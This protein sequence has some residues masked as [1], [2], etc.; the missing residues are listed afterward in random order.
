SF[1][2]NPTI[3]ELT[4]Q[5]LDQP[6]RATPS[7]FASLDH[8]GERPLSHGQQSLWAIQHVSTESTAYNVAFAA[9]IS[10]ELNLNALRD[11]CGRLVQRHPMLRASF[12]SQHGK[13]VCI[14]QEHAESLLR[15]ED[16]TCFTEDELFNHLNEDAWTSFDL[17]SGP[18][19]RASLLK[20][21]AHEHV[22]LLSAHHIIVDFWSLEVLLR[23][24]AQLYEDR[25][26]ILDTPTPYS[27]YVRRQTDL[28]AAFEGE[29]LRNYWLQQL[30]GELP[31]L[32]LPTDRA[33]PPM[34][35]HRGASV[36]AGFDPR[37]TNA[38]K[39][40][41][42]SHEATLFM[43]LLSA[44]QVL[45]SRYTSQEEFLV[46]SPSSGRV[47]A[48]FA[49]TIG[50][51]IN[52]L[53]LRAKISGDRSFSEFLAETRL[54]TLA[55]FEHQEYPFDLLVKQLQPARDPA[56]SPLFQ[57]MFAFQKGDVALKLGGL[58]VESLALDQ[59]AAQFDLSLTVTEVDSKLDASFEYNTDLFDRSTIESLSESFR[60]LLDSIVTDPCV[61]LSELSLLSNEMRR[62]VLYDWNDTRVNYAPVVC[63]HE[64]FAQRAA[65]APAQIAITSGAETLSYGELNKRANRLANYLRARGVGPEVRVG[66][67]VPRSA[68][69][70]TCVL[71]VLKAGGAYVPLDP[72]YPEERLAFMIE[73]S[74]ASLVL[75]E[76]LLDADGPAIDAESD[77]DP[78]P[79]ATFDNLAYVIYTSGST[80]TPKGV[81]VQHGSLAN[82]VN[83]A[84]DVY[85]VVPEDR[86]LQFFSFSFDGHA[87]EIYLSLT[88]GATLVLR[89][90]GVAK[91]PSAFLDECRGKKLTVITLPTAYWHELVSHLN[92]ADWTA[93][94]QLQLVIIGGEKVLAER[95]ERW[96][97]DVGPRVR[98]VNTYGPTEATVIA[99]ICELT[100]FSVVTIGRPIANTQAYVLDHQ[101]Q[102]L[103][104]GARGELY[105]G[106]ANISRGYLGNAPLTAEKFI[107]DPFGAPG[108][109]LYRTGDLARFRHDGQ[110]E[111]HGRVDQQ[112]KIRGHRIEPAEIE[113]T[114]LR[115]EAVRDVAVVAGGEADSERRLLAY[116]VTASERAVTAAELRNFLTG[117]LPKHMLPASFTVVAALP[118][119]PSGK[120]DRRALPPPAMDLVR[121]DRAY[122]APRTAVERVLCDL[123]GEVLKLERVGI[124]DN[125]FEL[126]GDSILS[127]Q[128]AARARLSGLQLSPT[129]IFQHPTP[130]TLAAVTSIARAHYPADEKITGDVPLT[131]IQRWFFEQQFSF[132]DHWNMA[133]MLETRERLDSGLL[134][135]AF[136]H[137][138]EHHDALHLRFVKA[139]EGW[140]QFIADVNGKT[141]CIVDLSDEAVEIDQRVRTITDETQAQLDLATGT[142]LRAVLLECGEGRP[143]RLFI[144][145]HHLVVDGVSWR[146]LLEDLGRVYR[147]LQH[148]E[149]VSFPPKTTSFARWA[150]LLAEYARSEQA[151]S[152]LVYWTELSAKQIEP[153][154]V[155]FNDGNN[156]EGDTHT[157]TIAL[158]S[159]ETQALLR[160]VAHAYTTQ[161][162]DVL[163]TALLDAIAHWTGEQAILIELEGHGREDLFDD[164]D[165]SRTVGWFTS[166]FPILLQAKAG[167]SP[168]ETLQSVKQQLRRIPR[169]GVGY[170]L[171]RYL[172]DDDDVAQE[173]RRSPAPEISFNYLGQWDQMLDDSALF[174]LVRESCGQTRHPST[175]R[176][177]LLEINAYVS[178]KRLQVDWIYGT[179]I[180]KHQTIEKLA[181][182]FVKTLRAIINQSEPDDVEDLYPLSP[183]Q[184]GMLFH[185]VYTP[186]STIYTGQLSFTLEGKL[187]VEAFTVAWRRGVARH[188]ILRSSFIWENLEE[189]LQ[190]V[191]RNVEAPLRQY[192]WRELPKLEQESRLNDLLEEERRRGFDLAVAPLMRLKLVQL[193]D[194]SYRFIWTHHHLLLDGWSIALLLEEIFDD[195]DALR[196][197]TDRAPQPTRP[198]RDYITWLGQQDG[199]RAKAFWRSYLDGFLA[200]TPLAVDHAAADPAREADTRRLRVRLS[201]AESDRLRAFARQHQLTLSTLFQGAWARLL[202]CYSR[203]SDVVYGA[204]VAGRP[205]GF[206]GVE[207]MVGLF[208]NTLPVRVRLQAETAVVA[209]LKQIQAEQVLAREYEHSP[210]V[211]LQ[212]LSAVPRGVPLFESLLVFEN[213]PLDVRA[214]GSD[215]GISASDVWWF[216]QTNYPL[217]VVVTP[218]SE[219]SLEIFYDAHRFA[220]DAIQRMLGHVQTILDGFTAGPAR[221]LAHIPLVTARERSVLLSQW[222]DTRNESSL[223]GRSVHYL[224]EEQAQK[225]PDRVALVSG[226]EQLT[227]AELNA[228]ANR[229]ARFL[230]RNGVET[231]SRVCICLEPGI[232]MIVAVLAV[233]KAGA[234]YVPLDPA[235]PD[236][237]LAFMLVDSGARVL[238]TESRL[239]EDRLTPGAVRA[240][241]LDR[242]RDEILRESPD[243]RSVNVSDDNLIYVIYTSGSTGRPKGAAVTHGGFINLVN[244]FVSEFALTERERVLIIASFSFDLTQKDIFSPLIVGGQL[245]FRAAS[246]YDPAEILATISDKEI[247]FVNCTPSAFYPLVEADGSRFQKLS[248]LKHVFLGGEPI[249]VSRLREWA[250]RADAEIVNTY[251]PTEATD[252][253]SAFRLSDFERRTSAPPIG[254]PGDNAELLILDEH[255]NLLP[256]SVAGELFIGGAGV[257]RGYVNDPSTTAERFIPHPYSSAP[258][259]RLY[260][261]GDLVRHLSDGN[262]EFLGRLDHQVKVA[263]YRIELGEIEATMVQLQA[264]RECVVVVRSD[265]HDNA[266]L[267]AYV[268]P[269]QDVQLPDVPALR[270]Y[271]G[272]SLPSHMIPGVFVSLEKLP[273]T[274]GGKVDRRALPAPGMTSNGAAPQYVAPRT[275]VEQGLAEIWREVLGVERVGI[276]DNF[277]DLGGHS[278]LA[279]R[280]VSGIRQLFRIELPLRVLFESANLEELA[281]AVKA[282]PQITR[283]LKNDLRNPRREERDD[284][285]LSFA[286]ERLWFLDQLEPGGAAYNMPGAVWLEG[287]LDVVALERSLNEIVRR[288]EILRTT[289]RAERGRPAQVISPSLSVS[290]PLVDLSQSSDREAEALAREEA[291]KPFD[292]TR[293]PLLRATLVR[294]ADERHLL[295]VT[296]HHIV[297]DGWSVTL[298]TQE[299]AALYDAFRN[300]EESPLPELELTYADYAVWQREWLQGER[301]EQQLAYW[302]EQLR[303]ELPVLKLPLAQARTAVAQHRGGL[304]TA[305]VSNELTQGLRELARRE[306]ATLF[307][308]LLAAWKVLL[309]RLSGERDIVV[310]TPVAGRGSRELEPLI[311]VFVNTL[312]LRTELSGPQSFLEVLHRVREVCLEA[313]AHQEVPFERIVK[314]LQPE[315]ELNQAPLFQ[316]L[317]SLQNTPLP[318]IELPGLRLRVE[319]TTSDTTKFDL[320]LE[321]TEDADELACVWQYE[322]GVFDAATIQR[323]AAHYQTLLLAIV[324]DPARRSH[325]LP[326][327]TDTQERALLTEHNSTH[328]AYPQQTVLHELFEEQVTRTPEALAVVSEEA[329][330]SYAEL[331][332]RAN[333]V[334][335]YLRSLGL[336][337]EG[338]VG[339]LL[340]RS[341]DLV[342]ALL[343]VLKAGGACVPLDPSYPSQRLKLLIE[344][345]HASVVLTR[346]T[347]A[348]ALIFDETGSLKNVKPQSSANV[349]YVIYTSGSSGRPKGVMVTHAA[350]CNHMRWMCDAF[351]YTGTDVFLQKTPIGFDASVWEFYM[352][353]MVGARLVMARHGGHQDSGYLVRT[354]IEH[355]VTVVQVVPTLLRMLVDEPDFSSCEALRLVFC[356]G[357]ALSKEL[358]ARCLELLPAT[359]LCNL[360]GPAETTIDAT[361]WEAESWTSTATIPIGK[362]VANTGAYVLDE[363]LNLVPVGVVGELHLDGAGLARG[364]EGRADLTAER[365]VPNPFRNEPG[366]RM[367]RTGDLVRRLPGG[368]LE[369]LGR[370]DGQLKVLGARVELGEVEAVLCAHADV[371]AA[372]VAGREDTSGERRLV[373]YVVTADERE[374]MAR[375]L[376][377]YL[378]ERLPGHMVPSVFVRME[379]LPLLPSGKVDRR[380]L[381]APDK[382]ERIVEYRPPRTPVEE[383]LCGIWEEVL[384]RDAVGA[385]DHFFELGGHSL[386]ATQVVSHVKEAFAVEL[387][388]TRLFE[389][390]V[391]SELAEFI[392]RQLKPDGKHT[393]PPLQPISRERPLP[394]S[395]AQQRLWFLDQLEP[396]NP[397]YNT[398]GVLR[399]T[400]HL[401][402]AALE[403]ALSE[404]VRRHEALRTTFQVVDGNPVQIIS[405]PRAITIP[406]VDLSGHDEVEVQRLISAEAQRP[407]DLSVGPLLRATLLRVRAEEHLLLFT[408]HHII[409]DGW[410]AGILAREAT[411]L[412]AAFTGHDAAPLPELP[413]QYADYAAWQREW[414]RGETLRAQFDYWA[415]QFDGLSPVLE[416]PLDHPRP[417]V[418]SLRGAFVPVELDEELTVGL[419][420]LSRAEGATLFMTLLAAFQTLLSRYTAQH[421]VAVGVPLANRRRREIEGL[422]GFFVNTLV[423]R[424]NL[425][426]DPAFRKLLGRARE[427]ALGAYAHQDLPFEMLVERFQPARDARHTP[428]FNVLFVFQNLPGSTPKF[429][430]LKIEQLNAGT[431]TAKFDLMLSLEE[432]GGR[433][434]GVFEYSTDLFD[435]STIRRMLVHFETMLRGI[436]QQPDCRISELPLLKRDEEQQLVVEWNQTAADFS[437]TSCIHN[438]FYEQ[439]AKT[440][441]EV[442][443][444]CGQERLTYRELDQAANRLAHFLRRDGV[445]PESVVAVATARSMRM[446]IAVLGVLKAGAAYLPLDPEYPYERLAFMLEDA[447]VSGVLTEQHLLNRIPAQC[448]RVICL[449]T[450]NELIAAEN[451]TRPASDVTSGNLAYVIY[452]SGSTGRPKAVMMPHRA[453]CNLVAFQLSSSSATART[454]QF[455]SL[456]FDVSVQEMFSTWCAGATLVLVDEETRRDAGA[457]LRVVTEQRVERLFLPFV[458]LQHLAEASE[459]E[460]F[461][462]RDLR[463]V[464]TAGEQLKITPSIERLFRKLDGCHLDNHYGPTETHLATMWRLQGAAGEWPRLP[465]IGGPVAN[466]QVYVLDEHYRPVPPG[467]AG[468]LYIGGEGLA[469]GYFNRPDQT[470]ER[471]IPNPFSNEAGRRLYKTGDLVR[472]FDAHRLEFVGRSDRQVKVRGFRVEVGEIEA[473]LKLHRDVRQAVVTDWDREDGRKLLAAYVVAA[474]GASSSLTGELKQLLREHLPEYMVPAVFV[475]MEKLPLL[476]NGK[477]DRRALPPPDTAEYAGD[478]QAPRTPIEE[479][480][481]GIW[482]QVLGRERVGAEDDFF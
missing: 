273:L 296:L 212:A 50:Y 352:P 157:L 31:V 265:A 236:S 259:A 238:L 477:V 294:L 272:D 295:L 310:G 15:V 335:R 118:R 208:I 151:R 76:Q 45:L 269:E 80:G 369:F 24:L 188:A 439:A 46:G 88:T 300:G 325:E 165:L 220:G 26:A 319:D 340:E 475:R 147:Q 412:Y 211:E 97:R 409:S 413:L 14:V 42:T 312:V 262:I 250:T 320:A 63:V 460:G 228:R 410:S 164:V 10:G 415:T 394:L 138:V 448:P 304:E 48:E 227:Y 178:N 231:E 7:R 362:P 329:C 305:R 441:D 313:Y 56:R 317:F 49:K 350:L 254:K 277:L 408:M 342:V 195:Y 53:A 64:S 457:L 338:R 69:M 297:A 41:A 349:A 301:L 285:P 120:I 289:F 264:V 428:F 9:R 418:R 225:T 115:H 434:G 105:L 322:H 309:A 377:S 85:G 213:Y 183:L 206:A 142:L 140:R 198:F 136:A 417:K 400:G 435:E 462:P 274:P 299:L 268:V 302:R 387:P 402:V 323:M 181:E 423:M 33:R 341:A 99:T 291:A 267:V 125:F 29:R 58:A 455:A 205:A 30:A 357:E 353:L 209:W 252:T 247:T 129:Q 318:Q 114:L 380:A 133:L 406:L 224:F 308:T 232:D 98:L 79:S 436:V 445:G 166:A 324:A 454:L 154:P 339:I 427:V 391:L 27:D 424:T 194:E 270:R 481:C 390:P 78:A 113:A 117:L 95:V 116:V 398:P 82:Y 121:A 112:V 469:R 134:E 389:T 336:P 382:F 292:L 37:L 152:E 182:R 93:A 74:G 282:E 185:T 128:V 396:G 450:D 210:L 81:M 68:A 173:M 168:V 4:S 407:F 239:L 218:G 25:P 223:R 72:A 432:S 1:L 28:L 344:D 216:D 148:G 160:D 266:R 361:Y 314:S 71:G 149:A 135:R 459:A 458:A 44:F 283:I 358:A 478:Y 360:Y 321:I 326:L 23:E 67:C 332:R 245:H 249:N 226:A 355:G 172:N 230:E 18:L 87:E 92:S 431:G 219:L 311:G 57:V 364:Y 184:Q 471:F 86:I 279:M 131:P 145:A 374:S 375:E 75:T 437:R 19:L 6:A 16:A 327:L 119:L 96:R 444:I 472:R 260:R 343:A 235:Y 330:L 167:V 91:E 13:P 77:A 482:E 333:R 243:N 20:S 397:L 176:G 399:L 463:E 303:G 162:N 280:C 401:D 83:A 276:H 237:R 351:A 306:G 47:S 405:A 440:P 8:T 43:T 84:N 89:D 190:S 257:G 345:S 177:Q 174:T 60:V 126:G 73:D 359:R 442:A 2:R 365:F 467:V 5:I 271:L 368:E 275:A 12:P 207:S 461:V 376:R 144:A 146:I 94:E 189:P 386:L 202:S 39:E 34:Q 61:H 425:A 452:T 143:Q 354:L 199:A 446:A 153:L 256:Q 156:I 229:L 107:P 106:G 404:I 381:P 55:A 187:D 234:A 411:T 288:H 468:E 196:R 241:C 70:V 32:D 161:V 429:P 290:L 159:A 253:C 192:D 180:H 456:N 307:M 175:R 451:N 139:P 315:R 416:L 193:D 246:V 127:I 479:V 51:F 214:F 186:G 298:L 158:D 65:S 403:R 363:W 465:P 261:T 278:M 473:T 233:L 419:K 62:Q 464:I 366:T 286:Q 420:A 347:L 392:E 21:A 90:D 17:E 372:A 430:G 124:H 130:A 59:R 52:P 109:R 480:L 38:L 215:A 449:D 356:G 150:K 110:I 258:G 284:I 379:Q 244:W 35:T 104:S 348:H 66:I 111:F 414:L 331:D 102:P 384:G 132:P 388:L 197:G 204:T 36:S 103:A 255:L 221:S 438:F 169:H 395:F 201:Q 240:L 40:L 293:G 370:I 367:Y 179:A 383:T 163:L 393:E 287:D 251:G 346:E 122:V 22:L 443:L 101:L 155:D 217:T 263:G 474:A 200:P 316:V 108:A 466:V 100:R 328:V 470:A 281:Q 123:W 171:L 242:E 421:D 170:G 378:K 337:P 334:A 54:T 371:V 385:D 433:L 222:N 248:S 373:A 191:S 203:E 476:P 137:L 422:I 426:G 447:H 11:A 141:F 3:A 453:I